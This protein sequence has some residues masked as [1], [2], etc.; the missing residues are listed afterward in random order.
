MFL[1]PRS[2][3][4]YPDWE[5]IADYTVAIL[6]GAAGRDP[7]DENLTKLIGE[8]STRSE[9]FCTRWAAHDVRLHR[10]G[11]STFIIRW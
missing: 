9:D 10:T 3:D 4:F 1:N 5:E 2:R 8:L 7:F 11:V 6:R